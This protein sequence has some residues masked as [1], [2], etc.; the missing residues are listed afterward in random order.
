MVPVHLGIIMDG[1]GRWAKARLMPRSY[2]HKCGMERMIGLLRYAFSQ[3]VRY[4]TLYTLSVENLSRSEEELSALFS[5]FRK[6]FAEY[7]RE[8]T[9]EGVRIRV[10]GNLSLLPAD[11]REIMES[12]CESTKENT[13]GCVNFAVAYS[14][15]AEILQAV[16]AAVINGKA[17]TEAEFSDLLYTKDMPDPDLII[18]TG[19]ERR[20]SNFLLWQSAYAEL[21]FS[22]KMFPDFSDADLLAAFADYAKRERRFGKA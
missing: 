3:G 5:L 16:N 10:S 13:N 19:G 18:R 6:Y 1:N 11:I 17:V 4:I 12:I 21:Y 14:A 22:Q 20:L 8:I 7:V 15:R 2:G 9:D